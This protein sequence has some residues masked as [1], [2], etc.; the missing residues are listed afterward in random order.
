MDKQKQILKRV[1]LNNKDGFTCDFKGNLI[2]KN[3]GFFVGITNIKGKQ[4]NR[5]INKILYIKKNGF[6]DLKDLYVGGWYEEKTF[7]LDLSLY[8]EKENLSK[9]IGKIF[10]QKAV[11]N[12]QKLKDVY[13][14]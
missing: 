4:L 12:I 7:Y 2:N 11:F 3:N 10:N 9:S 5:L 8:V 1:I 14:R 6:N 13:L